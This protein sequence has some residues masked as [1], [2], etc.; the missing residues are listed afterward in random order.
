MDRMHTALTAASTNEVYSPAIQAA[1][2]L[3]V[4]LL[5]KYYYLTDNSEVYQIA[6]GE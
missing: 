4:K 3:G 6:M 5:D 1:L 2:K